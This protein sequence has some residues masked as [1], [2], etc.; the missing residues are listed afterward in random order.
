MTV[1]DQAVAMKRFH[2]GLY[3]LLGFHES[4]EGAHADSFLAVVTVMAYLGAY[5]FPQE[6]LHGLKVK[7]TAALEPFQSSIDVESTVARAVQLAEVF[8]RPWSE[9]GSTGEATI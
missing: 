5:A 8:R 2:Q 3:Y 9:P 6:N 4:G 7:M 1:I